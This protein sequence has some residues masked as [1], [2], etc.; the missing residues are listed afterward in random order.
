MGTSTSVTFESSSKALRGAFPSPAARYGWASFFQSSGRRG[1][2]MDAERPAWKFF[3]TLPFE[4]YGH[5]E[6]KA[7]RKL[8][9]K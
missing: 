5:H 7:D 1:S 3:R 2:M 9:Q 6:P 4:K 8:L